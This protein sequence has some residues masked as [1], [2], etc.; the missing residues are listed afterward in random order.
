VKQAP[1]T[2]T[3]GDVSAW[4]A[5]PFKAEVAVPISASFGGGKPLR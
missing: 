1:R 3:H 4:T 5:I 2:D